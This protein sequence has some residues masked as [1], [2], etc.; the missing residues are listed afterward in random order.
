VNESLRNFFDEHLKLVLDKM[1]PRVHELIDHVPLHVEDYPSVETMAE[2]GVRRRE[3]LCGLYTGVPLSERSASEPPMLPDVV[4]IYREGI[5]S[6]STNNRNEVIVE[7]L[8]R[9]IHITILHELG[10]HHGMD[11]QDLAELGYD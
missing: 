1:P 11:E 3:A 4:T 6:Q 9:Q 5:L 2:L 8:R 10:H 7:E